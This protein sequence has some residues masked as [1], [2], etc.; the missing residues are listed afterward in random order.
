M[1]TAPR[2]ARWGSLESSLARYRV[3][4]YVVGVGL[5]VVVFVGIPLQ[6]WAS[7]DIIVQIV[8]TAHGYLYIVYLVCALDLAR[9]ARFTLTEMAAMVGAGLIPVL[10]FVIERKISA[11]VRSGS[12]VPW[13]FPWQKHTEPVD[14]A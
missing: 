9:R 12:T 7:D 3:M 5:A 6:V 13:R 11:K 2:M 10:A 8:G 1:S 4:A 14:R